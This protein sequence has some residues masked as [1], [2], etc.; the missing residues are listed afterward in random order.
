MGVDLFGVADL[1]PA[2]NLIEGQGGEALTRFPRAVSMGIHLL[3]AVVD[4]LH[5][6]EDPPTIYTYQFHAYRAVNPLLDEVALQVSRTI[7]ARSYHAYPIPA[8]QTVNQ[9]K[10]LGVFPHKLAA[11]LAGLGWIGKNCLL[12][13]PRYGPRVRLA[14]ILTDAPLSTDSSMSNRCGECR[15]C[16]DAC[17]SKALT[18]L[19]FNPQEP[20]EVRFNAR[21][22]Q[23]YSQQR[24]R[25]V[26]PSA[27]DGNTCGLCVYVC[28]WGRGKKQRSS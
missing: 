11:N 25:S 15:A 3:D 16:V 21:L 12:V 26:L 2:H 6:H 13:T 9:D 14:T 8:S 23:E 18:G 20:R 7:Q 1:N 27:L 28:P 17:P 5:L 4:Q 10:L 19:P 22:C 24:K